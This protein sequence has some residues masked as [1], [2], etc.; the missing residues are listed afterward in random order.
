MFPAK[1]TL[2]ERQINIGGHLMKMQ[3]QAAKADDVVFAVGVVTL[4]AAD[5]ALQHTVEVFLQD[6]LA[7]NVS[8]KP[9]TQ[10]ATVRVTEARQQIGAT[11]MDVSGPVPDN[12]ARRVIHALFAAR[13]RHVYQAAVISSKEPTQDQLDQFF[14]SL[15]LY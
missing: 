4:P 14:G 9:T 2:D 6:G 12:H 13:G 1:V 11:R 3:M 7:R 15:Q 10:A 5:P 8:S